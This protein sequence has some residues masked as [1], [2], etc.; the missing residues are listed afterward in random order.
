[1]DSVATVN[2]REQRLRLMMSALD[3]RHAH[4]AATLPDAKK[5]TVGNS[6]RLGGA[7]TAGVEAHS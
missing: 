4:S 7:G 1:M 6:E 5:P 3:F 2:M